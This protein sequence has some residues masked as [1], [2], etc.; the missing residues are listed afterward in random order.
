MRAE[1]PTKAAL[2][3]VMVAKSEHLRPAQDRLRP[4]SKAFENTM[5]V[6]HEKKVTRSRAA[7]VRSPS[8]PL[9]NAA[10]GGGLLADPLLV[11]LAVHGGPA[12]CASRLNL[13]S[14]DAM[15]QNVTVGSE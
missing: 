15:R 14:R 1:G 2:R 7:C 4:T 13:V 11:D 3:D 8:Q 9:E 5:R 10:S 12:V 6:R